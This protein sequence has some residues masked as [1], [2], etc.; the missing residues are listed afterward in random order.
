MTIRKVTFPDLGALLFLS[1]NTFFDAFAHLNDL[2]D[3]EAYAAA[4]FTIEKLR[5]EFDHPHAEFYFAEIDKEIVGYLKLNFTKAQ[6]EFQRPDEMEVERIYVSAKYQGKQ[7]GGQLI[8]FALQK[9]IERELCSIW[10]GVWEKNHRAIRFYQRLG[11]QEFSSHQFMLGTDR[12]TD[13][14]FRKAL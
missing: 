11:F 5:S 10:L 3:M 8:N 4:N 6:T 2:R 1:K 12:Q 14:L 13:L 9:G 7:I